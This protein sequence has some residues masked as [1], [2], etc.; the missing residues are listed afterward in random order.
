MF[1]DS[2]LLVGIGIFRFSICLWFSLGRLC[3]SRNL[4]MS[5]RLSNLLVYIV[6]SSLLWAFVFLWCQLNTLNFIISFLLLTLDFVYSSYSSSF[7]YKVRLFSWDFSRGRLV[8]LWISL[9]E[10]LLLCPIDFGWC[11]AI[12]ICLK[13]FVHFLFD[14]FIDQLVI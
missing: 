4:S 9:L 10:P 13:V 1:N 8:S 5:S 2:I 14:F 3:V 12:F 11:T 7:R 6:C